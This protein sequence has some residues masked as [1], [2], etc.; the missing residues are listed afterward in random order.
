MS[1]AEIIDAIGIDA[2]ARLSRL[3][4]SNYLYVPADPGPDNPMVEAIG[5]D[6]TKR[7]AKAIGNGRL[8]IPTGIY[9]QERDARISKLLAKGCSAKRLARALRISHRTVY[10]ISRFDRATDQKHRQAHDR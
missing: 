2:A 8:Y 6:A 5:L 10:H 4:G 9:R 7:L 3:L 1:A